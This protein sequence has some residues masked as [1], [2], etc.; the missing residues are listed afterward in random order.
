MDRLPRAKQT[1]TIA[2]CLS[3]P[4]FL[5]IFC[6]HSR[7]GCQGKDSCHVAS[8]DAEARRGKVTCPRPHSWQAAE[9]S[10]PESQAETR[11][12]TGLQPAHPGTC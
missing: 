10:R 5:F 1:P 4:G 7:R 2:Q 6:G 12:L 9:L 11:G 8:E 3:L